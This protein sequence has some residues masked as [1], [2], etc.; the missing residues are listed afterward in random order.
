MGLHPVRLR[1]AAALLALGA[2]LSSAAYAQKFGIFQINGSGASAC[3]HSLVFSS[4]CNSQY[5]FLG[6][7][8]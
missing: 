3:S 1:L 7:L 6:P 8:R 5:I 4:A 2:I